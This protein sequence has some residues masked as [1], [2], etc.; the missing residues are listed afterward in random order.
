MADWTVLAPVGGITIYERFEVQLHPF[1]LQLHAAMGRKIME[2]LWPARRTRGDAPGET[3]SIAVP[4]A[5]AKA[6]DGA[7]AGPVL[8]AVTYTDSPRHASFDVLPPAPASGSSS[9]A[10]RWISEIARLMPL[11]CDFLMFSAACFRLTV[12][13]ISLVI[14]RDRHRMA[15]AFWS[16]ANSFRR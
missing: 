6:D 8:P 1:R 14:G 13:V 11:A 9:S 12:S 3:E 15:S 10:A 5:F 4:E 7:G 2:Y 16:L